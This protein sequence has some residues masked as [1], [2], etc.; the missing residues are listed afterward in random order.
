M[1]STVKIDKIEFNR[2]KSL[3]ARA[4]VNQK[5]SSCRYKT[6]FLQLTYE[7]FIIL[8]QAYLLIHSISYTFYDIIDL[9]S[10]FLFT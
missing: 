8:I 9:K 2:K 5:I 7:Y 6:Q 4:P 3:V 1:Q 10:I